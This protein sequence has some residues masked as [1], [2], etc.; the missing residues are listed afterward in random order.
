MRSQ[1]ICPTAEKYGDTAKLIVSVMFVSSTLIAGGFAGHTSDTGQDGASTIGSRHKV[2]L[3]PTPAWGDIGGWDQP[4]YYATIQL[5]DI[6]G[7]G[8]AELIARGPS[9]ILVNRFDSASHAWIAKKPGPPLS[10]AARWDQPQYYA[11]IQFA[12]VDGDGQ[13]ELVARGSDG[14][15]VW[16]YDSR[17][18]CWKEL[19]FA[20]PFPDSSHGDTD[21]TP[22]ERP[23]YYTTIHLADI[24]GDGHAELVGRGSDGLH[25]YRYEGKS[26]SWSELPRIIELSDANG[27]DQPKHYSTIHLA[28]I[29][30]QAGAEV[31]ARGPDGI[32]VYHYDKT[33]ANWSSLPPIA[34]LSDA[35]GWDQASHYSSI[36]AADID[37]RPGAEVIA[38]GPD[39]LHVYHYERGNWASLPTLTDLS[40][41]NGWDQPRYNRTIQLAD[42]DGQPGA[43]LIARGREGILVWHYNAKDECWTRLSTV[44]RPDIASMSDAN[45]WN[46][47]QRYLTIQAG[48]IDG[49]PGAELI[50]RSDTGI[51]TWRFSSN[52]RRATEVTGTPNF[53][54]FTGVQNTYYQYISSKL[55][56]GSDIRADYDELVGQTGTVLSD[57]KGLAPPTGVLPSDA[58]WQA[59]T[60]QIITELKYVKAADD[61]ILGPQGSQPLTRDIFTFAGLDA[62]SVASKLSAGQSSTIAANLFSLLVTI[63]RGVTAAV[64]VPVAPG[65]GLL[66]STVFSEVHGNGQAPNL[67]IAVGAVKGQLATMFTHAENANNDVHDALVSNWSQLQAFAA[68]KVGI[69]PSDPYVVEMR[70]TGAL[71]YASWLWETISPAVW[72]INIPYYD[73]HKINNTCE[74]VKQYDYP[75]DGPTYAFNSGG[76]GP[77]WI[78]VDCGYFS[79]D[80][81]TEAAVVVPFGGSCP[82][83]VDCRDPVNGP[84]LLN[85]NDMFL[86]QNGWNLPCFGETYNCTLAQNAAF[87]SERASNA[88]DAIKSLLSL[89]RTTVPDNGA[90]HGLTEPLEAALVV[91]K[92]GGPTQRDFTVDALQNFVLRAKAEP[93]CQPDA[94]NSASLIASAYE[95]QGH[96]TDDAPLAAVYTRHGHQ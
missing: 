92:N 37:G 17:A 19:A 4:Q 9:G 63:A 76:C 60:A 62:D 68:S 82:P 57:L 81:V 6:D 5:A 71:G 2:Q 56:Y 14:I 40:D 70:R 96:L 7:D 87:E 15:Q 47:P 89:V 50:G 28:D 72:H 45:G 34:E 67:S 33:S 54:A 13:A 58:N 52:G 75:P 39:G 49:Q 94:T 41:S 66:L 43:E 18:D 3:P 1:R 69:V 26:R 77:A 65:I 23:Q 29:D 21:S 11:T 59:V 80:S 24:D 38:R 90:Q 8:R 79:C 88:R 85:S 31:I 91:L 86:G 64:G 46:L 20:G 25:V 83:G 95:I 74:Y 35:N 36:Q 84:L 61:W 55:G 73:V 48:Q 16:H 51:E 53:P 32:H 12:D 78:G 44:T 22:W 10:D 30:G 93:N 42:M 27:W